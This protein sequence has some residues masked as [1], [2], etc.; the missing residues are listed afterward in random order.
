MPSDSNELRRFLRAARCR[1]AVWRTVEWIGLCSL[2]GS[3]LALPLIGVLSW[4]AQPAAGVVGMILALSVLAGIAVGVMKRPSLLDTA[5]SADRQLG[6]CDLLATAV[7][8]PQ[9]PYAQE[10]WRRTILSLAEDRC[11]MN[12]PSALVLNRLGA[13]AWGGIGLSAALVVT[14]SLMTATPRQMVAEVRDSMAP[15]QA[16]SA[17][18]SGQR[19]AGRA[20]VTPHREASRAA[21]D[22]S[23][24]QGDEFIEG[25]GLSER[26]S[27]SALG[28]V[29]PGKAQTPDHAS[30]SVQIRTSS[31]DPPAPR[32]RPAG[33][34][35]RGTA[36][37]AQ[38]DLTS[39]GGLGSGPNGAAAAPWESAHW[40]AH[41][42]EAMESIRSGQ[43]PDRYRDL[44]RAYFDRETDR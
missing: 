44:V 37:H 33:G 25:S 1:W 29:G 9:V 28:A 16:D 24:D 36:P 20:S 31:P 19:D 40:T 18:Q 38:R 6:L 14:L 21:I 15:A 26:S 13:R 17:V 23:E 43:I 34:T 10:P 11:R 30:A 3:L 2:A 8:L 42:R 32:G 35:G 5:M 4:R 41:Q 12:R 27:G 39:V 22:E 7:M